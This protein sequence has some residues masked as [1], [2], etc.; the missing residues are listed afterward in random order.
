[1]LS[2]KEIA[3]NNYEL[4]K[5]IYTSVGFT[6]ENTKAVP[7]KDVTID[8][9]SGQPAPQKLQLFKNGTYNFV[10]VS[11]LA[12]EHIIYHLIET[13]DKLNDEGITGLA[14]FPKGTILF[15]KSGKTVL[16]NHRA[17]LGVS[18]Y[19]VSHLMGIIPDIQKI[20][21]YYLFGCLLNIDAKELLLNE[22]YPSIRK[23]VF[24]NI[25]I[26]LPSKGKQKEI[27]K[28]IQE[29]VKMEKRK[30]ELVVALQQ[31]YKQAQSSIGL[32]K[33]KNT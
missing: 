18:S 4:V 33:R 20:D 29:L 12:K 28:P 2:T 9:K 8:I 10:R 3:Q 1:M 17:I 23:G 32:S 30:N 5:G 25:V 27:S 16:K 24:E 19:V 11:D 22:G 14:I 21:P 31:N 6:F 13:R 15:P 26:P 7:L